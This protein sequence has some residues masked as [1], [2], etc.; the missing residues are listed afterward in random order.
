MHTQVRPLRNSI[1]SFLGNK[2]FPSVSNCTS[3]S[4]YGWIFHLF[5]QPLPTRR[6]PRLSSR[7]SLLEERR[8]AA[9]AL[10]NARCR[11]RPE[12]GWRQQKN[13]VERERPKWPVLYT[14]SS[15]ILITYLLI[16]EVAKN[17]S[18]EGSAY[19]PTWTQITKLQ[20][21]PRYVS[22]FIYI[23]F[24]VNETLSACYLSPSFRPPV[25]PQSHHYWLSC[26]PFLMRP[27]Q[28]WVVRRRQR[29]RKKEKKWPFKHWPSEPALP[30]KKEIDRSVQ[31][32]I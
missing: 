8:E 20:Q 30:G 29:Q 6:V 23:F 31:Q 11:R 7:S 21:Q 25:L 28:Q 16:I 2:D 32:G 27:L 3:R 5:R 10:V 24:Y 12:S 1:A 15:Y 26:L 19:R 17:Q 13:S 18:L 14:F 22:F 4:L 9:A